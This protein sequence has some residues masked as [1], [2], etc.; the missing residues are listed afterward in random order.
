M[1]YLAVPNAASIWRKVFGK[2]WVSGWFAPFHLFHYD[3]KSLALLAKQ[4]GFEVVES[5]SST[6]ES[7]FR[8][9]I[10][11]TIYS[12]ENLLDWRNTWLDSFPV[13]YSLMPLLRIAELVFR[14]RDCLVMKLKKQG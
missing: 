10:K 7:W 1:L 9:N 12:K 3:S 11:A 4:H 8:L 13:R 5:W 6:P 14:E 2:N